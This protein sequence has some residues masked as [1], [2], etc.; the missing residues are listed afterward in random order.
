MS[1]YDV[2][3]FEKEV[4]QRSHQI[5]VLVD[6][7]AEWCG[8]CKVL[9]PV[10]EALAEKESDCWVLA[11]LDTDRNQDIAARYG[12]RGI[13]AVKLF[14]DGN[15][16]SEFTGALP[17][18]AVKQWLDRAL[19]NPLRK[20]VERAQQLI[21]EGKPLEAQTILGKVLQQDSTY[22]DARVALAGTYIKASPRRALE[23]VN[24]I[25]E[26]SKNFPM[27]EAI[28]TFASL[29]AKL[30]D[31][32]FLPESPVRDLYLSAIGALTDYDY[33]RALGG[34]IEVIR[35]DR[36]Y[37][38]DGARKACITIFKLLGEDNEITQQYRRGFSSALY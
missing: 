12:I 36:F 30:A 33:A 34:F 3:D 15:V 23:L 10:L 18:Q 2:S 28:R 7:W 26:H 21:A 37:D 22:E 29:T 5:P 8:P 9:G 17:E 25:E 38:E 31:P 32:S 1:A 4:I 14:V 27:V 13:P 19:P 16:V 35:T 6:F 11:K 24:G 20:E